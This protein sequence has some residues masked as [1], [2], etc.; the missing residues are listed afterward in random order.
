[1]YLWAFSSRLSITR[2]NSTGSTWIAGSAVGGG[3][4]ER[5]LGVARAQ[6][7]GGG[8][9]DLGGGDDG[10][11]QRQLGGGLAGRDLEPHR[12]QDVVDDGLELGDVDRDLDER[13]PRGLGVAFVGEV[14]RD[15]DPGQRRAQLVRDVGEQLLLGDEQAGDPV[16]HLVEPVAE[17]ADLV[18]A[19]EPAARLQIAGA[20]RAR[21]A[22]QPLDRPHDPA[23]GDQRADHEDHEAADQRPAAAR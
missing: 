23:R 16:G 21:G 10:A 22:R 12:G 11:A 18:G 19:V 1:M 7:L 20:E 17:L 5:A 8:G 15:A 3:D 6:A 4:L 9:G 2:R 13:G 14:E